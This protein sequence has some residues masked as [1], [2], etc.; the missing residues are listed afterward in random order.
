MEVAVISYI[1]LL[2]LLYGEVAPE[3]SLVRSTF[4]YTNDSLLLVLH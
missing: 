3:N 2:L 4:T 1:S